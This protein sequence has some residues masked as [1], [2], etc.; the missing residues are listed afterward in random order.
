[1]EPNDDR[2]RGTG[3]IANRARAP[4]QTSNFEVHTLP[5]Y[6]TFLR[7]QSV[8]SFITRMHSATFATK[9]SVMAEAWL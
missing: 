5:Q 4:K 9:C 8:S 2:D 7:D 3:S 1:M 6:T